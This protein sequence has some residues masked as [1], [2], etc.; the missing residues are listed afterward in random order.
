M[1][2]SLGTFEAAARQ[3]WPRFEPFG[4]FEPAFSGLRAHSSLRTYAHQL[5]AHQPQVGERKQCHQV[6]RV[7]GQPTVFD[8]RITKLK[9]RSRLFCFM[10]LQC[11][12]LGLH[13]L[14][15]WSGFAECPL[16]GGIDIIDL[17]DKT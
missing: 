1:T 2:T 4:S 10:V 3:I 13:L 11:G 12:T 5:F 17:M 15:A 14:Y 8:L 16:L 6:G 9:F 7:L